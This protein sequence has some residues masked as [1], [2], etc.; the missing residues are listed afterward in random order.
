MEYIGEMSVDDPSRNIAV[1]GDFNA[2]PWDRSTRVY[3]RSGM[4]DSI[5]HRA[6]NLKWDD[7]SPLRT[8][9]TSGRLLDF[10]LL[11]PAA[12]EEYVIDSGFV[13]GSSAEEYNW[14]EDPIPAGYAS[15][16]CAI[17]IDMVPREGQGSTATALPWPHSI[18]LWL[19]ARHRS[20]VSVCP[21][22]GLE[23]IYF[24]TLENG[25]NGT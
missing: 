25:N 13:L 8:T 17:A 1:I 10:I 2:Q 14:R 12:L 7:M 22:L 9:H 6:A 23:D 16:H 15:D 4:T 24:R 3:F 11:N 5:S 21:R 20:A 19:T 18:F